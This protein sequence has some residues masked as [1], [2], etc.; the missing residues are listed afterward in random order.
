MDSTENIRIFE[1]TEGMK[2]Q[3]EIASLTK[4]GRSTVQY[5]WQKW[6]GLGL[7]VESDRRKGRM[8]QILSL[9][10]AGITVPR[11]GKREESELTF[12]PQ[13]LKE[14]L[15]NSKIFSN[16][17]EL[18]KFA[19]DILPNFPESTVFL[20]RP[21]E[22]VIQDVIQAFENSDRMKQALFMQALERRASSTN[23]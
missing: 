13:D 11:T 12:Q 9:D 6:Q 18:A 10:E 17:Y 23:S 4:L 3:Q 20:P 1:S 7:V 2:S 21:M 16:T 8:K 15:G 14:I 19:S 5:Y 22:N